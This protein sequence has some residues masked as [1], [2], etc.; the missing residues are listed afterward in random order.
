MAEEIV[1][2]VIFTVKDGK[3]GEMLPALTKLTKASREEEG[4]VSYTVHRDNENENIFILHEVWKST[5]AL[6]EH[7]NQP[8]LS[9][10][11]AKFDEILESMVF[12]TT[13][14]VHI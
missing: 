1:L 6:D 12:H 10:A 2:F 5:A 3:A 7:Q 8:H 9:E 13:S 11:K 14:A 4:C